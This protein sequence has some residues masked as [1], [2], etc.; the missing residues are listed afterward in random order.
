VVEGR[1]VHE[2]SVQ[3]SRGSLKLAVAAAG[4]AA[5]TQSF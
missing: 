3:E 2:S 5:K 4:G 1:L